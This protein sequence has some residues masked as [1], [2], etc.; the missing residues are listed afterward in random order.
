[1][2]PARGRQLSAGLCG[3][4]GS[5]ASGEFINTLSLAEI[6]TGWWEGQALMG[7]SQKATNCALSAIHDR[8]PFTLKE[9]HPDN[10]SGMINDL[11]WRF[12]EKEKIRMSRSRP[13]K[14]NDNCWVEQRNWSHV[15]KVVGYLRYDTRAELICLNELYRLLGVYKNFCQPSMKLVDKE[16][17]GGQIKRKYDEPKTPYERL[18]ELGDLETAAK[19][20]LE[21]IYQSLNPAQLKRGIEQKRSELYHLYQDK[22]HT[23]KVEPFKK[24]TTRLVSSF[25]IQPGAVGCHG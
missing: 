10:D 20:R 19:V 5:S 9:I 14:K 1:M 24:Q 15:R 3:N 18:C 13:L 17:V 2:G 25:M 6:A 11:I 23:L 22:M 4:C 12:C 21:K 7:R 8:L 16:R